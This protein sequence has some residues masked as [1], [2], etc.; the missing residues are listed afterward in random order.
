MRTFTGDKVWLILGLVRENFTQ[1][2]RDLML[3]G[4]PPPV[5]QMWETTGEASFNDL[6]AQVRQTP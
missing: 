1:R 5:R 4:M 2:Q 6:M 3:E